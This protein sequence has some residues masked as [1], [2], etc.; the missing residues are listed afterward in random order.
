MKEGNETFRERGS[1][2]ETAVEQRPHNSKGQFP[3]R[4]VNRLDAPFRPNKKKR[5][6]IKMPRKVIP[7]PEWIPQACELMVKYDLSL[8][9]AAA[10]LGQDISIEQVEALKD[11]K[12]L[13]EAL[14]S[15]RL[16]HFADI[17]SDYRLNR[18]AVVGQI[19]KLAERLASDREDYKAADA[20]LKLAKIRGWVG[21]PE[22]T[23]SLVDRLT[24]NDLD[25]LKVQVRRVQEQGQPFSLADPAKLAAY[26]GKTSTASVFL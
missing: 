6:N 13:K 21:E 20:L 23:P 2:S 24:Q 3:P 10:E 1:A 22:H 25:A 9:Q 11:R 12:L 5:S 26:V 17:G 14:E 8:R 7:L 15:A 19:F 4:V 18:D 16:R